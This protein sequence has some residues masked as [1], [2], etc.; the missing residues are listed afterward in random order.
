MKTEN[1]DYGKAFNPADRLATVGKRT[2]DMERMIRLQVAEE[3]RVKAEEDERIRNI[4]YFDS[5][6]QTTFTEQDI[7][8]NSVG[9]R[10]MKTQ[11]GRGVDLE[12]RDEQLQVENQ[13]NVRSQKITDEELKA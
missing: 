8:Y 4:R 12:K 9:R 10:V 11:D 6:N 3:Q 7:S 5:T 1:Y 2:L 13:F